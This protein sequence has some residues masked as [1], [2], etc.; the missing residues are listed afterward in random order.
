MEM[1][2][3]QTR[4]LNAENAILCGAMLRGLTVSDAI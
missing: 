1:E 4:R 3:I 2:S